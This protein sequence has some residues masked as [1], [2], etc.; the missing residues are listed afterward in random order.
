MAADY[1]KYRY[2]AD[3]GLTHPI[4]IDTPTVAAQTTA[5]TTG[6]TTSSLSAKGSLGRREV[7]LRPRFLNLTRQASADPEARTLYTR[8]PVLLPADFAGFATGGTVTINSVVWTISTKEPERS[9]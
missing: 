4:R 7:G 8:L 3:S 5:P 1:K 2:T 9:R 6:A